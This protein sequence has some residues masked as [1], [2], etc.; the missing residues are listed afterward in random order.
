MDKLRRKRCPV[1]TRITT[2]CAQVEAAV[3]K[4]P[5]DLTELETFETLE[6]NKKKLQE[7]DEAV[8]DKAVDLN[9]GDDELQQ[10]EEESSVYSKR[11]IKAT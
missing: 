7:L 9:Y 11:I 10:E 5:I 4:D 1:R 6:I 3:Q 2:T 8:M